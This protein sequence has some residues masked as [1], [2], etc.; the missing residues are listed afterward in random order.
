MAERAGQFSLIPLFDPDLGAS[1]AADSLRPSGHLALFWNVM[2]YS[3]ECAKAI[4]SVYERDL[5]ELPFFR[6]GSTGGRASYAPLSD[7]AIDGIKQNGAFSEPEE[8]EFDWER[9]YTR[10]E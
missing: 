10:D 7:K 2:S 8:W 9:T 4:T 5:P 6:G 3:P 1:R